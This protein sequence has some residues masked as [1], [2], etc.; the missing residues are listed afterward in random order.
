VRGRLTLTAAFGV[1]SLGLLA[2]VACNRKPEV[3]FTLHVPD[4]VR[5]TAAWYEV[6]VFA[7][8][9][10]PSDAQLSGGVPTSGATAHVAFPKDSP[11][12]PAIGDLSRGSYAFA[13]VAKAADCSVLAAGCTAVDVGDV[14]DVSI[15]LKAQAAPTGACGAGLVCVDAQCAPAND[16]PSAGG[17]CSMELLGA[18]PLGNPL[19]EVGTVMSYPAIAPTDKGFLIAYREYDPAGHA[20]LTLA[21][22]D[23]GGGMVQLT[24]QDL[25]NRC[26]SE[27]GD[28]VGLAFAQGPEAQGTQGLV[29]VA[30]ALCDGKSGFDLYSVDGSGK[31]LSR[32]QETGTFVGTSHLSLSAA[33]AMAPVLS[34]PASNSFY[35]AGLKDGQALLSQASGVQF[36]Q[37]ASPAFG[38]NPPQTDA[39]VAT[40]D[41]LVALLAAGSDD[42][43]PPPSDDAGGT[44]G[45]APVTDG[46][47]VPSLRLQVAAAGS[48]LTKLPA[49]LPIAGTWGSL[50]VQGTRL[51]VASSGSSSG[52][53]VLLHVFDLGSS[54]PTVEDG[55]SPSGLGKV[56]FADVAYQ[57]SHAFFAVEQPQA[58][59]VVAYDQMA[60][61]TPVFLREEQLALNPR[62]PSLSQ[63]RDGRLAI[64]ATDTR[65]ALV[66]VTGRTLGEEDPTG[67]YAI[68]ACK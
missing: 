24:T 15:S 27:E 2:D 56:L 38:G 65:V 67:G 26:S 44:D 16:Q 9:S 37:T 7:N 60:T 21:L 64:A 19:A 12:P 58:I 62:V 43:A 63:V 3:S 50:A 1:L 30:R 45:S 6:G 57:K 61:N 11:N 13:A 10:C 25:P 18:G 31:I 28:A 22:V 32:G 14:K 47:K 51:V 17:G 35:V 5:N 8:A 68:M 59:S 53:S 20:R 29:I 55:F 41:K 39:W 42:P 46:G 34:D 49:P 33:H 36:S 48:D 4:D 66:W 23:N 40:S 52:E 54:T